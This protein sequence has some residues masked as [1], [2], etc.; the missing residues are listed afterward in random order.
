MPSI[1]KYIG[2]ARQC[3]PLCPFNFPELQNVACIAVGA[4]NCT[5]FAKIGEGPR[6]RTFSL[7]EL[8]SSRQIIPFKHTGTPF[9][10]TASEVATLTFAREVLGLPAPDVFFRNGH[11][12]D[13]NPI[14]AEYIIMNK[15]G[16][17]E[18]VD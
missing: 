16:G 7:T 5:E 2:S 4:R 17:V 8:R 12:D 18:L 11:A 14:G 3:T 15:M 10:I 9:L 6:T 1:L 13:R